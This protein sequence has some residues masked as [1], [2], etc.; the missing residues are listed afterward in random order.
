MMEKGIFFGSLLNEIRV[1]M[2]AIQPAKN[3]M[4]STVNCAGTLDPGRGVF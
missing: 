3:W 1:S 2:V 4:R